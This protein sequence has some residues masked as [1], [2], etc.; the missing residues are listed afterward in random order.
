MIRDSLGNAHAQKPQELH[1]S[2]CHLVLNLRREENRR[3]RHAEQRKKR[4][5]HKAEETTYLEKNMFLSGAFSG[6]MFF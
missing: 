5:F 1:L 2:R 3:L 4:R 6:A